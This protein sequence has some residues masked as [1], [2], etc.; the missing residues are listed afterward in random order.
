MRE[1]GSEETISVTTLNLLT[2]IFFILLTSEFLP[3]QLASE[4]SFLLQGYE[5]EN[6]FG[7]SKMQLFRLCS[8]CAKNMSVK[9]SPG[10]TLR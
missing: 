6:K 2:G 8:L 1:G 3:F 7:G 5:Y 10:V 4:E 9:I